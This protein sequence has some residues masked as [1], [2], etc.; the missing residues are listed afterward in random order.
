M[1]PWPAPRTDQP[2]Q[3][4]NSLICMEYFRQLRP[5]QKA[6]PE[7]IASHKRER[8]RQIDLKNEIGGPK[9]V[10]FRLNQRRSS[11]KSGHLPPTAAITFVLGPCRRPGH[12][13]TG[14]EMERKPRVGRKTPFDNPAHC[15]NIERAARLINDT[16]QRLKSPF[17]YCNVMSITLLSAN[18]AINFG[19]Q[20]RPTCRE[21]GG[22]HEF[23]TVVERENPT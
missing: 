12:R 18:T 2:V 10:P 22:Q 3:V 17:C 8:K 16:K 15:S 23:Q 1:L 19:Q 14:Q 21:Q 13:T 4:G 11:C 7:P 20:S 5:A 6:K 9:I